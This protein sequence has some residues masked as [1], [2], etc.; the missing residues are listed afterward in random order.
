MSR[1]LPWMTTERGLSPQCHECAGDGVVC[2]DVF[3]REVSDLGG[4]YSVCGTCG[5]TGVAG[6]RD[7]LGLGRTAGERDEQ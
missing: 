1:A 2:D 3:A 4:H 6:D 7:P 5:G